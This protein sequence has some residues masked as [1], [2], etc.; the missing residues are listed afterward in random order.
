MNSEAF[1]TEL[2]QLATFIDDIEKQAG[3]DHQGVERRLS[4][5]TFA[6]NSCWQAVVNLSRASKEAR[7]RFFS[8]GPRSRAI[9]GWIHELTN[10]SLSFMSQYALFTKQLM[11]INL[12]KERYNIPIKSEDGSLDTHLSS[13]EIQQI[14]NRVKSQKE[15][16]TYL[17]KTHY[18]LRKT[19]VDLRIAYDHLLT[20]EANFEAGLSMQG[21][22]L[23]N[24]RRADPVLTEMTEL[25]LDVSSEIGKKEGEIL[26]LNILG[27]ELVS[28]VRA[29]S[30]NCA[31]LLHQNDYTQSPKYDRRMVEDLK[32][33]LKQIRA[34]EARIDQLAARTLPSLDARSPIL[35][36][37]ERIQAKRNSESR[38]MD[39]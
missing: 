24:G 11:W 20:E 10:R 6:L 4:R 18:K 17:H 28:M 26:D 36:K 32:K 31:D 5:K 9:V 23:K 2:R 3:S 33:S 30:A 29:F 12:Y 34:L 37:K 21:N 14:L 22:W 8:K 38:S 7:E 15:T 39:F 25:L 19:E 13:E 35:L 1:D 16:E 27:D